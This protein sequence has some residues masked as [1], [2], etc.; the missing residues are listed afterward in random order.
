[1]EVN[2]KLD[3]TAAEHKIYTSFRSRKT[4]LSCLPRKNRRVALSPNSGLLIVRV[5]R[6]SPQ[7]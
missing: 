3:M 1:M 2:Y 7:C 5:G 6:Y 4:D